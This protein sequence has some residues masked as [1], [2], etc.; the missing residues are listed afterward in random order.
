MA[1]ARHARRQ[2]KACDKTLLMSTLNF[3]IE[4]TGQVKIRSNTQNWTSSS[5]DFETLYWASLVIK[6]VR[7]VQNSSLECYMS[8]RFK[9]VS[10][11]YRSGSRSG[12][13]GKFI[14]RNNDSSIHAM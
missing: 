1:T 11:K 6:T 10:V 7:I 9:Q 12:Y 5:M 8:T 13:K 4:V 14:L 3:N 2:T